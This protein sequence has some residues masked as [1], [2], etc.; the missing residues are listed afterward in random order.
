MI[1]NQPDNIDNKENDDSN[2]DNAPEDTSSTQNS[3]TEIDELSSPKTEEINL[4]DLRYGKIII[5]TDADV[6]GSHIRSLLLTFFNNKPFNTQKEDELAGS[7]SKNDIEC[8]FI[9]ENDIG[10]EAKKYNLNL[11]KGRHTKHLP[12]KRKLIPINFIT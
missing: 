11:K 12:F 9:T 7:S 2:Q 8:N 4:E 10:I 5:M 3:T 6:D 1:E